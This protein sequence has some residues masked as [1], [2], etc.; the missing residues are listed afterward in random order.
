MALHPISLR[1]LTFHLMSCSVVMA[2]VGPPSICSHTPLSLYCF[3]FS[4]NPLLGLHSI[5]LNPKSILFVSIILLFLS[6]SVILDVYRLG[7]SGDHNS[8]FLIFRLKLISA[9][10]LLVE[11]S[12]VSDCALHLPALSKISSLAK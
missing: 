11:N 9:L 3:P 2:P 4:I 10:L 8:V 5:Y 7:F 1:S 12:N 6:V